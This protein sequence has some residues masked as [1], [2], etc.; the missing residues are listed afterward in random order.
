MKIRLARYIQR[1]R[2]N[3][4]GERFVIWVQ[5]C[6]IRCPGC[7]NRD[8]WDSSG[9]S[10]ISVCDLLKKIS[11]T[12]SLEGVT[13]SGGEPLAQADALL[14]LSK[15]CRESGLSVFIFT[16]YHFSELRTEAQ[17]GLWNSA[18][19]VVAG[20]YMQSLR[21][22]EHAWLGSS[23]QSVHFVSSRY[24]HADQLNAIRAEAHMDLDGTLI[25]TGFP[26]F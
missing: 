7:W 1:S 15:A 11:S 26:E 3:G 18:D 5:G 8:T 16:G 19:I 4:P 17:V 12:D 13:F 25:W 23:N 9:G 10:E 20:P 21:S 14:E 6:P 2:A 22:F 24:S